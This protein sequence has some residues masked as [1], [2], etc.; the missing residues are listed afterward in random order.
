MWARPWHRV[1]KKGPSIILPL[2][3]YGIAG[4]DRGI[5]YPMRIRKRGL[6]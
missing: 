1:P 5:V 6:T 2:L 3:K 4:T